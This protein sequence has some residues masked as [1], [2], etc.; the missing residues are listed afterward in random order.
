MK[1]TTLTVLMAISLLGAFIA[2]AEETAKPAA[3]AVT[4]PAPATN[5]PA[6]TKPA[7]AAEKPPAPAIPE[8]AKIDWEAMKKEDRKMYMKTV[9]LPAAQKLFAAY[10]AK[11]YKRVTCVLCHGG[12][13]ADG[14]FKMPNPDLPKLPATRE[15]F[16]ELGAKKPEAM[17]FM[18]T[19]VKPTLAALLGKTEFTPQNKTGF[20]CGGCHETVK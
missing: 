1:R 20:G 7:A 12:G 8:K 11:K 9:V 6:A 15:G 10:D 5:G 3:T 17:K 4:K 16:M 19:Q 13:G 14:T 2:R 18:G